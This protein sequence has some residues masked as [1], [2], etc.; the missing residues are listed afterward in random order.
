[1]TRAAT[2][3]NDHADSYP[4]GDPCALE[5][6]TVDPYAKAGSSWRIVT[7]DVIPGR[8][9]PQDSPPRTDSIKRRLFF[10]NPEPIPA[11]VVPGVQNS[12]R[13]ETRVR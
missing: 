4:F 9:L 7:R 10:H 6:E 11:E 5:L 12:L 13:A 3:V 8:A 2:A 1:V